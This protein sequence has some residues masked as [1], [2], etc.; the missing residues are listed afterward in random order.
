[1]YLG[2]D[3]LA[4][5]DTILGYIDNRG[6][7]AQ[8][9]ERCIHIAEVTGSRPVSPTILPFASDIRPEADIQLNLS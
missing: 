2:V 9:G 5:G 1:M 8:L 7:L 3:E 4:D 6:R